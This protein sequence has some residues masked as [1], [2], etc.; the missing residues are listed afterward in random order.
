MTR[1]DGGGR[2]SG[3]HNQGHGTVQ[4]Q[5]KALKVAE[6]PWETGTER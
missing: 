2:L 1:A 6:V 4:H 3:S 5:V